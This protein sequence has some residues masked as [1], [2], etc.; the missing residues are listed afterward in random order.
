MVGAW[1]SGMGY[2]VL[3]RGVITVA[4]PAKVRLSGM[5]EGV[6]VEL[7]VLNAAAVLVGDEV[8]VGFFSDNPIDGVILGVL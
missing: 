3:V 2:E 7:P 5:Y 6:V 4:V 8:A 1:V